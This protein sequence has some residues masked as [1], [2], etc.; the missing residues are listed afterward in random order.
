MSMKLLSTLARA[1]CDTLSGAPN[2]YDRLLRDIADTRVVLLGEA[3]HGSHEFYRERAQITKRLILEKGFNAVAVEA[4][5]PDSFRVD[6]YVRGFSDDPD[7]T[8]ALGG[9]KRFPQW[10]WRNADVLDFVGWLREYNGSVRT[11]IRKCGF[12]GLD[13]YS[14][15][16]SMH[17]VIQ[18]LDR[19]DPAAADRARRRYACFDEFGE[20]AREY[21]FATSSGVAA[22]CER[23]A[24][25]QLVEMRLKEMAYL[26]R[27]GEV[28]S[29]AYF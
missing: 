19:I 29:D 5:W 27:D 14:L 9:F 2:D 16:A 21:G 26:R 13:L 23:E 20:D 1:C 4:D 11:S 12:Y 25:G 28:A 6:R 17:A 8:E 22:S 18:Y 15:H 24:V 3:T 7:A 10:M